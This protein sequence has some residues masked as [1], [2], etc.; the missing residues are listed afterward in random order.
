[1]PDFAV[2]T[3]FTGKGNIVS[4]MGQ[5]GAAVDKFGSRADKAFKK[6]SGSGFSLM[7][8]AK[9]LVPAFGI[10]QIVNYANK[11]IELASALTEVQNVVDTTF[12]EGAGQI[13]EWSKNAISKFGLSELQAK[14]F[15]GTIGAMAKGAGVGLDK[16]NAMSTGLTGLA[17]DYASFYN[18][19]IEE[20]FNKIRAGLSGE[21]E[22]LKQ[23]GKDMSAAGLD[24][25][26][27]AQ[28][29]GKTTAQMTMAEK[30]QLRYAYLMSQSKDQ[31]G[32]FNKTLGESYANQKRVLGVQF[33]QALANLARA[34]LPALTSAFTSLNAIMS[35]I[36]FKSMGEYLPVILKVVGAL[37]GAW[38]LY[39]G[40]I[41]AVKLAHAVMDLIGWGKALGLLVYRIATC[42]AVTKIWAGVQWLLNAAMSA[43][44]IM[45]IV[46][47]IAALVGWIIYL[48]SHL[49]EMRKLFMDITSILD[50]PWVQALI[51][52]LPGMGNINLLRQQIKQQQAQA[53]NQ[54]AQESRQQGVD[55][56]G[57]INVYGPEGTQVKKSNKSA[58]GID[59]NNMG[60]NS[61]LGGFGFAI[62]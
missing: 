38:I 54:A 34:T 45:I 13:N 60:P 42:S 2:A 59:W 11:A 35:K 61:G 25:F 10:Y 57:S 22:P 18:L 58:P 37:T 17:G 1:M 62:P 43:N 53:P 20:A 32:D 52:A 29:I 4:Y 39:E 8:V 16:L 31:I 19:P 26:A 21:T 15:T 40:A 3:A 50:K 36:D 41:K 48:N 46:V 14:Q 24:A 9:M 44:P 28:G 12:R 55:V 51:G 7:G 47:A 27:L 56:S 23:I 33:D 6:A 49:E 30:Y 5:A